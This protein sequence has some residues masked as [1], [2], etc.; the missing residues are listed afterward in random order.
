[1]RIPRLRLPRPRLSFDWLG[2]L[3]SRQ[4]VLYAAWT[5]VLFV[6]FM[7]MN[8]PG[9]VIVRRVVNQLDLRPM[10]LEFTS[11]HFAWFKGYELRGLKLSTQDGPG[12]SRPLVECTALDVRPALAGLLHGRINDW[13]WQG[14][15]YGGTASGELSLKDGSGTGQIELSQL[16]LGRFRM[17]AAQLDEGQISGQLS[18]TISVRFNMRDSRNTQVNADV[19]ITRPGISAAKIKGFKIPDLQF[20]QAKGKLTLKGDRLDLQEVRLAGDQLNASVTG[21]IVLRQPVESSTLNLRAT[22]ET[23]AATPDAIKALVA[24][25]PRPRTARPDAPITIAGTFASPQIR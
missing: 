12:D 9:D 2:E 14:Q 6:V 16:S 25:I 7:I 20:G 21:Q 5:L 18:G 4:I 19:V 15:L 1:M 17:L 10:H 11:G 23:S 3:L 8:F 13:S 24:F 22:V